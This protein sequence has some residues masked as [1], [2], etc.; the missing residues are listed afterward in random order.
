[1]KYFRTPAL[2]G[3]SG[4]LDAFAIRWSEKK[5]LVV[6]R[7]IKHLAPNGAKATTICC[8]SKLNSR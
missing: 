1:M 2:H 6:A 4:D 3:W 8:T 7:P 5:S